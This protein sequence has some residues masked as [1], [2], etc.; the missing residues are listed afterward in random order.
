L[1]FFFP[2]G[3]DGTLSLEPKSSFKT[4]VEFGTFWKPA[5]VCFLRHF[6]GSYFFLDV[7]T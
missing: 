4:L 6:L 5:T 1:N 7:H 2:S 3:S